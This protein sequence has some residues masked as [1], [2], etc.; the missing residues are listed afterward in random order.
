[1]YRSQIRSE[2]RYIAMTFAACVAALASRP[3]H[4]QD[5]RGLEICSAEKQMERRTGCLQTNDEYL[6]QV[7]ERNARDA[8]QKLDA[9]TRD[10]A[11]ARNEIAA[12]KAAIGALQTRIDKLEKP[13]A[14]DKPKTNNK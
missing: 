1:M 12:L 14:G 4:A 13:A 5:V 8:R 10:L 6:Q 3:A 11:A 2:A 7:I 9:T